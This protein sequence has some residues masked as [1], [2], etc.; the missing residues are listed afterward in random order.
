MDDSEFLL[1]L[2]EETQAAL[3]R[4]YQVDE[5]TPLDSVI[6]PN[7]CELSL[8]REDL[9]KVH[10]YKWRGAFNKIASMHER[11]FSGTM[12]A[13]SAGNHAQGVAVAAKRLQLPTTI[14]MPRSTPLVKQDAV[15][16]FGGKFVEIRLFGDSFDEA[17][18][19]AKKFAGQSGGAIIPPYD[20]LQVIAGQSTIGEELANTLERPPTHAFLAIGGGGMAAGV[21]SVFRRRFPETKLIAVEAVDQNSL[22]VS[23]TKG[24]CTTIER[25]DPFCD[26]T[27]VARPGELPFRICKNMIH[28][29]VTVTNDQVCEAIEYLWKKKRTIVEPSA[30]LGVA[31]AIQYELKP[32][33]R[34]VT[35]LSGSNVDFMMLPK[36]AQR[37]QA[38]WFERR[39]FA[40]EIEEQR[41]ALIG[42]LDNF[43]ANM[44]IIDFQYG[45]VADAH[46]YPVI[47]IEVRHSEIEQLET[48]LANPKIPAHHEVTGSAASEFRVIPFNVE[49]LKYPFFAVIEFSNRPGALGEFMRYASELANVCYM[50]YTDT[51][52]TE[53]YA[54]MGFEFDNIGL[55]SEFLEWLQIATRFQVVP[56]EDVQHFDS[57][58]DSTKRWQALRDGS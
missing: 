55:Q 41:G 54:L 9:S 19:E 1:R 4:V 30:A 16:D 49:L 37:S 3:G 25:L 5:A 11:D 34:P 6:L 18:A 35:V 50:N 47:G 15:R 40:F 48:F 2:A 21:S 12:V 28:E 46:A 20:D 33:D 29:Y 27:A 43:L 45:K 31:A 51:G 26:G 17:L 10:S 42:L 57:S 7:G 13:A 44:N 23:V 8:K 22:H 24:E 52:Q 39:Y 53:G 38:R 58:R 14:F 56:M 32:D 36:I